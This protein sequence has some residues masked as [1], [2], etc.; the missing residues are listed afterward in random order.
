MQGNE[1]GNI[2]LMGSCGFSGFLSDIVISQSPTRPESLSMR[3]GYKEA[4]SFGE[5]LRAIV[6]D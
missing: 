5:F 3:R 6:P 1:P 2:D 4:D